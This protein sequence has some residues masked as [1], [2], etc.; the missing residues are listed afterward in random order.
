VNRATPPVGPSADPPGRARERGVEDRGGS[1]EA[2]FTALR[3]LLFSVAYRLLG[4]PA[5]AED[6][7]QESWLR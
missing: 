6:V 1:P 7:V 3:P 4:R 2:V 5:D